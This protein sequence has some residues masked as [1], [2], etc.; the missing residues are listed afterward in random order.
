M[1]PI[2]CC[3][4]LG[5]CFQVGSSSAGKAYGYSTLCDDLMHWLAAPLRWWR[6]RGPRQAPG[7]FWA[8]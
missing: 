5:K 2:V 1:T 3:Q 6:Q 8:R 4:S 7:N